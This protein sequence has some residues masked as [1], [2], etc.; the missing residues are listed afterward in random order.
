MV[1]S[2][3]SG[4]D[5]PNDGNRATQFISDHILDEFA[6]F[7]PPGDLHNSQCVCNKIPPQL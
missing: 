3:I 5:S 6:N 7:S 2:Q 4:W 1:I